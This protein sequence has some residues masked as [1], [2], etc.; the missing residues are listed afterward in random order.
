MPGFAVT[1]TKP[2]RH[3]K[4]VAA[5]DGEDAEAKGADSGEPK[6][7]RRVTKL[8]DEVKSKRAM[9][10]FIAKQG[11]NILKHT[12]AFRMKDRLERT[13]MQKKTRI[14]K[15]QKLKQQ[16]KRE[17]KHKKNSMKGKSKKEP[18]VNK[19]SGRGGKGGGKK[20]RE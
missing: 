18:K 11:H 9:G 19:T 10:Q 8:P 17:G 14:Q 13:R 16:K 5:A 1:S 3:P 4:T 15:D 20:K 7:R 12:K 6:K 2:K